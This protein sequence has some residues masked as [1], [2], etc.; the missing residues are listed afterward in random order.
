MVIE[1]VK[2]TRE[3]LISVINEEC[4]NASN[5]KLQAIAIEVFGVKLNPCGATKGTVFITNLNMVKNTTLVR[6]RSTRCD[7]QI[8]PLIKKHKE[9]LPIT[10]ARA[11]ARLELLGLGIHLTQSEFNTAFDSA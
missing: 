11:K 7:K 9:Q 6:F 4:Q 1:Q 10:Q 2:L 8:L 5:E 3:Q